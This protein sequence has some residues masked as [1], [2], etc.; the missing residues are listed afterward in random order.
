MHPVGGLTM[1]NRNESSRRRAVIAHAKA[2]ASAAKSRLMDL[3][4]DL[5]AVGATRDAN[6]LGSIIGRLEA[7]QVRP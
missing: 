4:R 6:A 2:E 7:W 3:L 1:A 5:E